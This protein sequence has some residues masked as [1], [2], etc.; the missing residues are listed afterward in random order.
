MHLKSNKSMKALS[1]RRVQLLE[2]ISGY[3]DKHCCSPTIAEL[4]CELGISR[5]TV[6][7]HVGELRKRG[8]LSAL[9]GRARS[10][11]LSFEA[12]ELLSRREG[13]TAAA[14]SEEA[15][16]IPLAGRVAAGVPIEA[17]ENREKFSLKDCFGNTG[18]TFA[19]EV[20]G[21]SMIG[22][23][24]HDGDYVICRRSCSADDG[25]LVVAAVEDDEATLKRF[26]KEKG[27][28]R[29]Q[30]ANDNYEAIYSDNCRI[31]GVVVGLVRK[32]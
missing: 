13:S 18:E 30:P 28:V 31:E 17:V 14:C 21:D 22:E 15:A 8:L 2:M 11:K 32:M 6:F 29:L 27:R 7:E 26:Y 16:P 10:L 19:L 24:I 25:Q 23:D 5:S 4:S 3:Q 12:Q 20:A 1:P 9:P